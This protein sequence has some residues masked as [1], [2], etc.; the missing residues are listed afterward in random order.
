MNHTVLEP[1]RWP[2]GERRV[3]TNY[4]PKSKTDGKKRDG[5]RNGARSMTPIR[6]QAP[7]TPRTH[8]PG[9]GTAPTEVTVGVASQP[10]H[11]AA[12]GGTGKPG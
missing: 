5:D 8:A 10:A 12:P 11:G 4:T 1:D 9:E 3:T 6:G 7:L 2:V